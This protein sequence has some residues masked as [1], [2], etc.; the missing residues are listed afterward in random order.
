MGKGFILGH[1]MLDHDLFSLSKISIVKVNRTSKKNK[2]FVLMAM[3]N[4]LTL[5]FFVNRDFYRSTFSCSLNPS[6]TMV[7]DHVF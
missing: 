2:P 7:E 4:G 3:L 5:S 6:D 1:P